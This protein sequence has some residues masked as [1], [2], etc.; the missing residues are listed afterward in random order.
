MKKVGHWSMEQRR[1]FINKVAKRLGEVDL[2]TLFI[3]ADGLQY[4]GKRLDALVG[5]EGF[6]A[7]SKEAA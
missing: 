1:A 6:L 2:W 7:K 3:V 5:L 4:R